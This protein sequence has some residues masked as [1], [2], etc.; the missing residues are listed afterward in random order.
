MEVFFIPKAFSDK[1]KDIINDKLIEAGR[2]LFSRFGLK[3]TGI[4]D[5]TNAVGISQGSFYSFYSSKEELYFTVLEAEEEKI[6]EEI[7]ESEIF[8]GE[9]TAESF[10]EF[11]SKGFQLVDNNK[12]LKRLYQDQGEYQQIVRKLPNDR[13]EGHINKDTEK[14][15]PLISSLQEKEKI[16]ERD[17]EVISGLLRSL[18]LLTLHKEEIGE[19]IYPETI[20][21]IIELISQGLIKE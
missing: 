20:E 9:I 21:L 11:L 17:P 19:D 7:L 4:K 5:I 16:I 6:Q 10:K 8:A 2:D 13:I 15:M 3:K 12:M 14:L 1:E 18:F